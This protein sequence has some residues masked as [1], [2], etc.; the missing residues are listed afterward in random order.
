[1]AQELAHDEVRGKMFL[2]ILGSWFRDLIIYQ[3]T[4]EQG[5]LLNRDLADEITRAAANRKIE[6][7]LQD[8]WSLLQ[9]RQGLEAHGNLQLSLESA[10]AGIGGA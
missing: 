10:L 8:F 5:M 7:L 3:E 9:I 2:E 6:G 1:V 4:G